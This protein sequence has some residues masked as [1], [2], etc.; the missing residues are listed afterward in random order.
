MPCRS[1]EILHALSSLVV[2]RLQIIQFFHFYFLF[3]IFI[4]KHVS[5]K[6]G[7]K[8]I[9]RFVHVVFCCCFFHVILLL[10][11]SVSSYH[12]NQK[13]KPRWDLK[14]PSSNLN[15]LFCACFALSNSIPPLDLYQ[16]YCL[17]LQNSDSWSVNMLRNAANCI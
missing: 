13:Q 11:L 17:P 1:T 7:R 6:S 8:D 2:H 5:T 4:S 9:K 3:F 12:N 15:S 14:A 10:S 16:L